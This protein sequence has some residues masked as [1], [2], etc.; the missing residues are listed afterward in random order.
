MKMKMARYRMLALAAVSAMLLTGMTVFAA[1]DKSDTPTWRNIWD[2]QSYV[3]E[4][5]D[6]LFENDSLWVVENVEFE[7]THAPQGQKLLGEDVWN[8]FMD[9]D[10]PFQ[11]ETPE[12]AEEDTPIEGERAEVYSDWYDAAVAVVE[13]IVTA[14]G[15]YYIEESL[16]EEND[17]LWQAVDSVW[18]MSDAGEIIIVDIAGGEAAPDT[19]LLENGTYWIDAADWDAFCQEIE[20]IGGIEDN[21]GED[22]MQELVQEAVS[23][24]RNAYSTLGDR[25]HGKTAVPDV[26]EEKK[27]SSSGRKSREPQ[28]QEK[29]PV[30]MNQVVSSGGIKSISSIDGVYGKNC[31]AGVVYK[32][33]QSSIKR[34]SGLTEEEIKNGVIVKY[35]ICESTDRDKTRMLTQE[36]AAGQWKLAG[37]INND[38]YKL[39]KGVI[40][41]VNKTTEA[42]TVLLG[43]PERLKD[44]RYEFAVICFD[45]SGNAVIMQDTDTDMATVM[46]QASDFGCW[47]VV[48]REKA[49]G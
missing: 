36:A 47:A 8:R 5:V 16:W 44:G 11:E 13:G 42:L 46:V 40:S 17:A 43:V 27:S 37:I 6:V 30:I 14:T 49:D 3:Y 24:L 1:P 21:W 12:D 22:P 41:K 32:D 34:A 19:A 28:E 10:V 2:I 26:T 29:E 45:E 39:N 35:Y 7:M 48:Y 20:R 33:E 31:M 9:L 38:L 4:N 18:K 15:E 25:L 23:A